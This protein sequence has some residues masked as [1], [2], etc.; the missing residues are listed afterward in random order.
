MPTQLLSSLAEDALHLATLAACAHARTRFVDLDFTDPAAEFALAQLRAGAEG[1]AI[2]GDRA[3]EDGRQQRGLVL[4]SR[5]VDAMARGFF[6]RHSSGVGVSVAAGLCTRYARLPE[7]RW[8]DVDTP[9]IARVKA[10]CLPARPG[11][12][13]LGRRLLDPAWVDALEGPGERSLLLLLDTA[14]LHLSPFELDALLVM[15]SARLPEG[16][17]I[18][19]GFGDRHLLRPS[20]ALC[21]QATLAAAR[22][23]LKQVTHYPC[24]SI[25]HEDEYDEATRASVAGLNAVSR[26]FQGKVYPSLL[27][28]RVR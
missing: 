6:A 3:M 14:P 15:L 18:V 4:L 27:H 25:V 13:Q 2:E 8:V 20:P 17:E 19:L 16:S 23:R 24:L 1:E 5:T 9:A 12:V 10:P 26:L 11:Y 21:C 7:A 28:V 22:P